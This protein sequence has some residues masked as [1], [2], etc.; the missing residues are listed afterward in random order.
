M[1]SAGEAGVSFFAVEKAW[2]WAIA[3][4]D[5]RSNSMSPWRGAR[6]IERPC[7]Y[8]DVLTACARLGLPQLE[9]RVVVKYGRQ[10]RPPGKS[11]PDGDRKVWEQAMDRL[12]TRLAD[13]GIVAPAT[14]WT[15]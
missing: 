2:F 1:E 10:G 7:A 9:M 3:S 4:H 6:Q 5:A 13:K 15:R 14:E 12:H 11:D 8:A